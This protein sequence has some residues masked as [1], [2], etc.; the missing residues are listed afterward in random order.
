MSKKIDNF[1]DSLT[2]EQALDLRIATLLKLDAALAAKLSG[3]ADTSAHEVQKLEQPK[4]EQTNQLM[5]AQSP[6]TFAIPEYL[7]TCSEPQTAKQIAA[8]LVAAGRDFETNV[9]VRSVRVALA[10]VMATNPD[11]FH[12]TWCKWWLKSKCTK[13]QLEKY[14]AKNAHFGT[15]GH[16]KREHGKRTSAGIK[17][18]RSQGRKWG[19]EPK[20]TPELLDRARQMFRDGATLKQV[21]SELNVSTWL[22]YQTDIRA[23]ALRKEGKLLREG[24]S[25]EPK[26]SPDESADVIPLH[27]ERYEIPKGAA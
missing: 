23:L 18:F 9:P 10:K 14:L 15:G 1:V 11:V 8:A 13:G 4:V 20:A 2:P 3:T 6:L 16:G 12:A 22:L 21:C 17:K 5:L 27:G 26:P 19:R 7:A 25:T 24:R